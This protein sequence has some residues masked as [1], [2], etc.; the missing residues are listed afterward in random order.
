MSNV[1]GV[2]STQ[3]SIIAQLEV[4]GDP[5]A[6]IA[7]LAVQSGETQRKGANEARDAYESAEASEDQQEVDAMRQKADDIRSEAW[8]EG[9]GMVV[10][11][12]L[13]LGG[14]C[15]ALDEMKGAP[16]QVTTT[17]ANAEM[18]AF[19]GAGGVA[20]G[21]ATLMAAG[22]KA[23]QAND[24]ASAA[25][26][27][28]NADQAKAAAEDT[29]DASKDAGDFVKAALDFYNGYVSSEAQTRAAALHR[30]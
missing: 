1:Q 4:S 28:G 26:H 17:R 22:S 24:D 16:S 2:Q 23:A 13:E 10:Q 11:G 12:G 19:R 7:A 29:H 25:Q 21:V 30:A 3:T 27:R 15:E 8:T 18:A 20:N 5:G 14:S 6:E 9:V